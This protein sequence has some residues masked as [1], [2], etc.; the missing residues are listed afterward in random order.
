MNRRNF[1]RTSAATFVS[2][3]AASVVGFQPA[4]R[5][6]DEVKY[7]EAPIT[8]GSQKIVV[9]VDF[10]A[11]TIEHVFDVDIFQLKQNEDIPARTILTFDG[12]DGEKYVAVEN[13]KDLTFDYY[14]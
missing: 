1:L 9:Q 13:S 3:V 6:D 14:G 5:I 10:G 12:D 4:K 11:T 8:L 2:A 7:I